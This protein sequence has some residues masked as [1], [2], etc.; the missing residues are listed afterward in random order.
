MTKPSSRDLRK[1]S[2]PLVSV[3]QSLGQELRTPKCSEAAP[4]RRAEPS[5]RLNPTAVAELSARPMRSRRVHC[6]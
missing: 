5:S 4:S 3:Y 6:L 1:A 2:A